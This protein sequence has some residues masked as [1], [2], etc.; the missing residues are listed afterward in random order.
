MLTPHYFK[1]LGHLMLFSCN[2][3]LN[4]Q[5]VLDLGIALGLLEFREQV[6]ILWLLLLL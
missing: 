1:N 5:V 6:L 4:V 3:P 2:N